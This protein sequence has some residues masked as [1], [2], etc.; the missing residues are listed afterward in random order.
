LGGRLP[1]AFHLP[2]R[3]MQASHGM[4]LPILGANLVVAALSRSLMIRQLEKQDL[5]L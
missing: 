4:P 1:Q 5:V 3:I 2:S